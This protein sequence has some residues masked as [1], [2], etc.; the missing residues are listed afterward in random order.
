[1]WCEALPRGHA[2][3]AALKAAAHWTA[4][5][6]A[7]NPAGPDDVTASELYARAAQVAEEAAASPAPEV[8]QCRL[9]L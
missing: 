6:E 8:G 1:V 2:V 3:A 9:T 7:C 5:S 4:L